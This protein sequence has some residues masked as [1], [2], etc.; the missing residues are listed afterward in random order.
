MS[1]KTLQ[2][3]SVMENMIVQNTQ[4]HYSL[5]SCKNGVSVKEKEMEFLAWKHTL[6]WVQDHSK[7]NPHH[8]HPGQDY[9]RGASFDLVDH[10]IIKRLCGMCLRLL[11]QTVLHAWA[12][13]KPQLSPQCRF[14]ITQ[15]HDIPH[16]SYFAERAGLTFRSSEEMHQPSN[17]D[18]GIYEKA[19]TAC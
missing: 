8:C 14:V 7:V 18:T 19:N 12:C 6:L 11:C 13:G 4:K 16:I 15:Q 1:I 2:L 9:R 10:P 17:V 3:L 5:S